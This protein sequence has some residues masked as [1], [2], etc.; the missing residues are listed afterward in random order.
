MSGD[1]HAND[2][3][4][5]GDGSL[6]GGDTSDW[7]D[8][9]P[10]ADPQEVTSVLRE[11]SQGDGKAVDRLMPIVYGELRRLAQSFL[12]RERADHTLQ[13]TA[14]VHEAYLRLIDQSRVEWQGRAHFFAVASQAIRR[15]L[16]DHARS[17]GRKKRG[18][19]LRK[20]SLDD[21]PTLGGDV[22]YTDLV[23]LDEAL[24]RFSAEKPKQAQAVVMR[25]FGGLTNQEVA[26][27]MGVTTRTVE[28]YWQFG[29]AWLYREL[30]R[31]ED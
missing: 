18:G 25:F 19:D 3:A 21:V 16:V 27:V 2:D 9:P 20:L 29:R 17:R 11:A 6:P 7:R 23:A 13:A 8:L 30:S 4:R 31:G 5:A 1:R 28:S 14:L 12:H 24:A 22:T 10:A 26:E 15:I